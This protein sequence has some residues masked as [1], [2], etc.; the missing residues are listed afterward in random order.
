MSYITDNLV[1]PHGLAQRFLGR[2]ERILDGDESTEVVRL[3]ERGHSDQDGVSV[4]LAGVEILA[5]GL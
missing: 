5:A 4:Q 3:V 2:T 1:L